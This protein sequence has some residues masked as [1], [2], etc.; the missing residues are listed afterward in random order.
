MS[1]IG[2]VLIVGLYLVL[3]WIVF[4]NSW[5]LN[6]TYDVLKKKCDENV[7]CGIS[8]SE[9][10]TLQTFCI[11]S[12]SISIGSL[13]FMLGGGNALLFSNMSFIYLILFL[14]LGVAIYNTIVLD[15]HKS[16]ECPVDD[17]LSGV[18]YATLIIVGVL[19]L[20]A[21]ISHYSGAKAA[22][23]AKK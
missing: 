8:E 19:I 6:Y 4:Y 10:R 21:M 14:Q 7:N 3:V 16:T 5:V 20:I 22:A 17:K 1:F 9:I 12:I 15:S 13:G 23:K 18:N 11:I 2:E